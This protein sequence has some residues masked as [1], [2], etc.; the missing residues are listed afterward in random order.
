MSEEK[1]EEATGQK[2]KQAK[3]KGQ[4]FKSMDVLSI[5]G[6]IILIITIIFFF[7]QIGSLAADFM[8]KTL[9][10]AGTLNIEQVF[11]I[12]PS[13]F[14][15]YIYAFMPVAFCTILM[16]V[17]LS[18]LQTRGVFSF[19]PIKPNIGKLNPIKGFKKIFSLKS[20]YELFKGTIRICVIAYI[21]YTM[22]YDEL[23]YLPEAVGI[24]L[25]DS[26]YS[27]KGFL[28][29]TVIFVI[30]A[31]VPFACI[32]FFFQRWSF[33]KEMRMTKKEVKDE[34]KKQEGDPEIK[35]KRRQ[36]QKELRDKSGSLLK[37]A[38]ADLIVTNPTYIAIALR[39]DENNMIAPK[40]VAKGKGKLAYKIRQLAVENNVV[41]KCDIPLARML[42]KNIDINNEVTPEFYDDIAELYRW[43]YKSK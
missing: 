39:Y 36:I 14:E 37:V 2:L 42:Y 12:F 29:R 3:D 7:S 43:F 11:D 20:L 9:M 38:G 10:S 22:T 23:I 1:S 19:D 31:M 27:Y 25:S 33:N 28:V 32:D 41:M 16:A 24:S 17:V 5:G 26:L 6:G 15:V 4:A 8:R 13:F 35:S 18:I 21:I 30:L 40:V 34:Y